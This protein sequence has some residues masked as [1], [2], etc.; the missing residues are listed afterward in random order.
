MNAAGCADTAY[1]LITVLEP[2]GPD[3]PIVQPV[4]IP[5]AFSPNGDGVN[6]ILFVRGGPFTEFNFQIY[7]N[8]GVRIFSSDQQGIGWNGTYKDRDQ[9]TGVYIYTFHGIT[10]NGEVIDM[11]GDASIIR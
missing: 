4:G 3:A 8:W 10:I 2:Q 11:A 9:P 7:D 1:A 5:S 6:D